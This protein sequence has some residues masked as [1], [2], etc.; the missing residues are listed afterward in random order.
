MVS[1]GFRYS[2]LCFLVYFRGAKAI[3]RA[4]LRWIEGS[5]REWVMFLFTNCAM[6]WQ[7]VFQSL[8]NQLTACC[9]V[10]TIY[11]ITVS[12]ELTKEVTSPSLPKEPLKIEVQKFKDAPYDFSNPAVLL[13][14]WKN[15]CVPKSELVFSSIKGK[16]DH[17]KT[18][19]VYNGPRIVKFIS[20]VRKQFLVKNDFWTKKSKQG[21]YTMDPGELNL[22]KQFCQSI[23]NFWTKS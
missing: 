15:A 9:L 16:E 12:L 19:Q 6:L 4:S 1:N 3:Y 21:K 8:P 11:W 13:K 23:N 5:S 14:A 20:A 22:L 10:T 17:F 18:R 7:E 2:S